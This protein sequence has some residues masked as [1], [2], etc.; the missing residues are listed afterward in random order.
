M[1][2]ACVDVDE[3][4]KGGRDVDVVEAAVEKRAVLASRPAAR[5]AGRR[6]G[7]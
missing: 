1:I 7:C 2:V 3:C 6:G 4:G 5:P